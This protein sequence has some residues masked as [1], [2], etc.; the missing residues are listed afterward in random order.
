MWAR[1]R[2]RR[3]RHR[4]MAMATVTTAAASRGGSGAFH[5]PAHHPPRPFRRVVRKCLAAVGGGEEGWYGSKSRARRRVMAAGAACL[6]ARV[7]HIRRRNRGE[8]GKEGRKR[9]TVTK[10]LQRHYTTQEETTK[11]TEEKNGTQR[12]K[13]NHVT[14]TPHKRT[15][16]RDQRVGSAAHLPSRPPSP[17]P[18]LFQYGLAAAAPSH[19][20]QNPNRPPARSRPG[21]AA[22][23][24]AAGSARHLQSPCAPSPPPQNP[25]PPRLTGHTAALPLTALPHS[26]KTTHVSRNVRVRLAATRMAT[27]HRPYPPSPPYPCPP[28]PPARSGPQAAAGF[29]LP[30]RRGEHAERRVPFPSPL[31]KARCHKACAVTAPPPIRL[32]LNAHTAAHVLHGQV[33]NG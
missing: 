8:E 32:S 1:P 14:T 19:R 17:C 6:A 33:A 20:C 31:G 30:Q 11:K 13:K 4:A 18:C 27:Q 16:D 12:K 10:R 9:V 7:A 2:C 15:M 23:V 29:T 25:K 3:W 5:P 28:A 21:L 24:P 26:P 22:R